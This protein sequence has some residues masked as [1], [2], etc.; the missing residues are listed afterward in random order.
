MLILALVLNAIANILMK[1]GSGDGGLM[2]VVTDPR[3]FFGNGYLLFG[4]VTFVLA[5]GFYT[6]ALSK[7]QLSIAYPIMT[8]MGFLIVVGQFYCHLR[9]WT[10]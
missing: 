5:L 8:S 6:F 2:V 1:L 7:I 3:K 9:D 4:I 10:N